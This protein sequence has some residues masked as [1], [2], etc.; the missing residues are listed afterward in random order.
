MSTD[1]K[2]WFSSAELSKFGEAGLVDLPRSERWAGEKA[3]KLG[4][5]SRVV[6]SKGGKGGVKTEYLPSKDVLKIIHDYLNTSSNNSNLRVAQ[7]QAQ[8]ANVKQYADTLYIEH[9]TQA[10]AAAGSGQVTPTDQLMVNLAVNAADWRNYVGADHKNIKVITVYGDSMMPTLAHGDQ[11]L[12]DTA[13]HAF[14]DD[15]IYVIEQGDLLRVKRVKLKLDGSIL[16]KSD[17]IMYPE[18]EEYAAATAVQFNIIGKF[19]PFKF[20]KCN[21]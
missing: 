21:L 5:E 19:I 3:I 7:T 13:C 9:Y 17:N 1:A 11:I 10:R 12:V 18:V 4:W 8:Y 2:K 6:L 14:I 20:V 16:V 15:A